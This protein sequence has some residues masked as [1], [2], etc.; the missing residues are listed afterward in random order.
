[1]WSL[2]CPYQYCESLFNT[3]NSFTNN[4]APNF[5][6]NTYIYV[7]YKTNNNN[8]RR[9]EIKKKFVFTHETEFSHENG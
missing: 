9:Y 7:E 4:S 3:F 8:K 2:C 6:E 5:L 1:M